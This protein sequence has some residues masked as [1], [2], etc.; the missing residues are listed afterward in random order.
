MVEEDRMQRGVEEIA[1]VGV[2]NVSGEDEEVVSVWHRD[3]GR[4][5]TLRDTY[6]R[7]E[8]LMLPLAA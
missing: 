3:R 4:S 7:Y 8:R 2:G 6:N 1:I 5:V